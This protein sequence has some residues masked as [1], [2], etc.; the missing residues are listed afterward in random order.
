MIYYHTQ[1]QS[2]G[3]WVIWSNAKSLREAGKTLARHNEIWPD[4]S[5][6]GELITVGKRQR[7]SK[8]IVPTAL[9]RLTGDK[10]VCESKLVML[11]D[12]GI[13]FVIQW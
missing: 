12:D 13:E 8:D 11:C 9:Y 5:T 6:D 4:K 10:L 3:R 7:G 1:N 2:N